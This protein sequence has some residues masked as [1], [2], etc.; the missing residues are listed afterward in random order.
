MTG[1]RSDHSKADPRHVRPWLVVTRLQHG[2]PSRMTGAA[3]RGA[4][5]RHGR[6]CDPSSSATAVGRL[7]RTSRRARPAGRGRSFAAARAASRLALQRTD[8]ALRRPPRRSTRS[9]SRSVQARP[10]AC[11]DRTV[12]ARRPRS[13]WSAGCSS[14]TPVRSSSPAGPS[15]GTTRQG[16]HRLRPAGAFAVY[17]GPHRAREPGVLRPPLRAGRTS[18]RERDSTSSSRRSASPIARTRPHQFSGGM[19]R[20]LNIA[21]GLLHEPELLVLDEP[22]VGVDPQSRNAILSSVE[23]SASGLAVL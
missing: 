17:P 1:V 10:T 16:R 2:V 11:S 7:A 20:R 12:P 9:A 4:V 8:E 22:T 23:R 13:R 3:F 21:V 18:C 19:K 5:W 6:D 15:T 14:G